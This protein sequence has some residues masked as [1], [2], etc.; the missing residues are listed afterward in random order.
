MNIRRGKT[1]SGA[2]NTLRS[3]TR[4][5]RTAV[6]DREEGLGWASENWTAEKAYAR[7]KELKENRKSGEGPQTLAEKREIED[8]RKEADKQAQDLSRKRKRHLRRFHDENLPSTMQARQKSKNLYTQR[9]CFIV[10]TWPTQ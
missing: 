10:S 4:L 3:V 2:I 8:K 7:L 6:K 5:R 1:V 9:K